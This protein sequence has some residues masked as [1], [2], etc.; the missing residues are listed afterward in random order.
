MCILM[1][2]DK[3]LQSGK[4]K[5]NQDIQIFIHQPPNYLMP[6]CN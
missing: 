1:S 5:H 4:Y 6:L 3:P 2:F